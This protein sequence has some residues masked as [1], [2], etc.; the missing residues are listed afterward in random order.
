VSFIS[1]FAG[2]FK[3]SPGY[4]P[5]LKD[6]YQERAYPRKERR[7]LFTK[8]KSSKQY[9]QSDNTSQ[10]DNNTSTEDNVKDPRLMQYEKWYF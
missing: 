4:S 8:E 3:R 2:N 10:S 6:S 7:Q 5:N 1:C 9:S